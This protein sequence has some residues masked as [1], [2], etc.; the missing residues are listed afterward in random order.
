MR[1]EKHTEGI[2]VKSLITGL[3]TAAITLI[4]LTALAAMLIGNSTIKENNVNYVTAMVGLMSSVAGSWI[5]TRKIECK[6]IYISLF[7][8]FTYWLMLISVTALFFEGKYSGVA[9]TLLLILAGSLL[10]I[11]LRNGKHKKRYA[12]RKY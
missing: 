6:R 12:S 9:V 8:A 11:I 3:L 4:T 10:P 7:F 2:A 1:K 5:A